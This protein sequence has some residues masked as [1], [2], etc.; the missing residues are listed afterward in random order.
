MLTTE[1]RAAAA[2]PHRGRIG[3]ILHAAVGFLAL[4]GIVLLFALIVASPL[5]VAFGLWW[6]WRRRATERLLME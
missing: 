4:E 5:A 3:R 6:F 1:K 2:P